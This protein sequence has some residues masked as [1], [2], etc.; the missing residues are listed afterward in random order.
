MRPLCF[1]LFAAMSACV[2]S[3]DTGDD[4]ARRRDGV[5]NDGAG[6]GSGSGGGAEVASGLDADAGAPERYHPL[7]FTCE[8]VCDDGNEQDCFHGPCAG[9]TCEVAP[10]YDGSPCNGGDGHC[11]AGVCVTGS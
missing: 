11:E 3:P 9:S 2:P 5:E 8:G 10:V 1:V 4:D 6:G 7:P